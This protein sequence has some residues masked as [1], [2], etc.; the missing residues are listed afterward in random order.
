VE[1]ISA[2]DFVWSTMEPD[3]EVGFGPGAIVSCVC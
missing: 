1:Y 2:V 3:T